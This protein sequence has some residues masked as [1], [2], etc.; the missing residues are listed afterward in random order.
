[1]YTYLYILIHI[2][3]YA[4][5]YV[6]IYIYVQGLRKYLEPNAAKHSKVNDVSGTWGAGG[7]MEW[8]EVCV[9]VQVCSCARERFLSC[10]GWWYGVASTSRLLK[11]IGLFCK[12]A[13]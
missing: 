3:V 2:Y 5:I 8:D 4:Y 9:C 7:G 12:R 11:I 10:S 13:L 1:M 6:Y